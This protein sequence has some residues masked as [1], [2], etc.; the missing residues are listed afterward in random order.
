[1][2]ASIFPKCS[3]FDSL[4]VERSI[5]KARFEDDLEFGIKALS[6]LCHELTHIANAV[7]HDNYTNSGIDANESGNCKKTG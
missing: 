3:A 6:V 2:I 1:M 5:V 4:I 7:E